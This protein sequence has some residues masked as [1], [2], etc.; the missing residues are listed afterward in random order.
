MMRFSCDVI[1]V[2][3]YLVQS[4]PVPA[5]VRLGSNHD[6]KEQCLFT[7]L[8]LRRWNQSVLPW[9]T[10]LVSVINI[11]GQGHHSLRDM[12]TKWARDVVQYAD[13]AI[14][15]EIIIIVINDEAPGFPCTT[16]FL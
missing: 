16:Y 10:V 9:R 1:V 11:H 5:Q 15:L 13:L 12:F 6:Y 8:M 4:R 3:L 7:R 2:L 14:V